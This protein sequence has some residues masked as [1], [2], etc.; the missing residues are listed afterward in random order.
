MNVGFLGVSH[1][2]AEGRKF[3]VN[4][5]SCNVLGVCENNESIFKRFIENTAYPAFKS[6]KEL[7]ENEN[8]D[9][10][11]IEGRNKENYENAL[12]CIE[13]KKP[14]L[15]EKP[16]GANISQIH[17]IQKS[18]TQNN[19]FHQV[20]YHMRYSPSV[21][22]TKQQLS[23]KQIGNIHTVRFHASVQKPWLTNEWFCDPDDRGGLVFLDC[24]HMIDLI[25]FL[26]GDLQLI[27][28]D[29]IKRTDVQEHP[30]EDNATFL[31][32]SND[33]LIAGDCCGWETNDW[34]ETWNI[35]M[36]G[37]EGTLL[38]G[39][40][41]PRINLYKKDENNNYSWTKWEQLD[42]DGNL[43]YFYELQDVL[44][45]LKNGNETMGCTI[46][47]AYKTAELIEKAYQ[48]CGL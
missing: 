36:Y 13:Y 2:H 29:I 23:N 47:E 17:E 24:C 31:L 33:T 22:Y 46:S 7:L 4:K 3:A 30:Y 1:P 11:I 35:E 41:P 40:H 28:G 8:L 32:R 48:N 16:G 42:F 34:I 43:N 14:F 45:F 20:G 27:S 10:V 21:L 5:L 12:L 39:V 38:L 26:L 9:L 19:V 6:Q 15:I 25:Y 37:D 44:N 18:A